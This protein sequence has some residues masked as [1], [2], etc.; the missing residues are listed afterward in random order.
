MEDMYFKIVLFI[1][2]RLYQ[3]NKILKIGLKV[4]SKGEHNAPL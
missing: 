4:S 3:K 2:N 1:Q